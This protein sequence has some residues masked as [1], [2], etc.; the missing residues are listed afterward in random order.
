MGPH[1]GRANLTTNE[2][3]EDNMDERDA[4]DL[5]ADWAD[6]NQGLRKDLG[7]QLHTQ[8]IKPIQLGKFTRDTGILELYLPTEFAA[9]WVRD[10]YHDR[11]SLA[12][13][14]ASNKVRHVEVKVHPGRRRIADIDL[15]GQDGYGH[16]AANDG[17]MAME[18]IGEDGFTAS[19]GL[20][21]SQTFASF[22]TGTTKR[23]SG[24]SI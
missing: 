11:L 21:P 10:R 18:S 1:S 16:L 5:A 23:L 19:I 8:W 7:H 3:A 15:K 2:A 14:I 12:W 13:K 22:V 9:N 17:S 4:V 24:K 20:D 6:I